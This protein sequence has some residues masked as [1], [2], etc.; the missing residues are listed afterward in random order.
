MNYLLNLLRRGPSDEEI[1]AAFNLPL[2][3]DISQLSSYYEVQKSRL[4][5]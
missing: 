4:V 5:K 3:L 1:A 2:P